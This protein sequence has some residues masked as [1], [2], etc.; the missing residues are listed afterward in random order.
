MSNEKTEM[1]RDAVMAS[2]C[3]FS[4]RRAIPNDANTIMVMKRNAFSSSLLRFSIYQ[5]IRAINYLRQI[6]SC[7]RA[8]ITVAEQPDGDLLGYS[9]AS[10]DGGTWFLGYIAV[11]PERQHLG[12][13]QALLISFEHEGRQRGYSRVELEVEESNQRV[14][15][16]YEK[17]KYVAQKRSYHLEI[18]LES[19]NKTAALL[20]CNT[21]SEVT[22]LRNLDQFGFCKIEY[23]LLQGSVVLGLI[24]DHL[25]K[26]LDFKNIS[27]TEVVHA[28]SRRFAP[29]RK[30]LV[31]SGVNDPMEYPNVFTQ[32][33]V[34]RM[35]KS[36]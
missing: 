5:D 22:A 26:L 31:I 15:K 21:R 9:Q 23:T 17:N 18:A 8:V 33:S 12:V 29:E 1:Q 3:I 19:N 16:W 25:C 32:V 7:G 4:V 28:V 2:D 30:I 24:G 20:L 36:I 27:P 10:A 11:R 13:G 34:L 35:S 14:V 6:L